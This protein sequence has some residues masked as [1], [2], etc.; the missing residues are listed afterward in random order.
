MES[1]GGGGHFS[2]AAAQLTNYTLEEAV[3]SLKDRVKV[4]LR[5]NGRL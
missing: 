5:D 1:Y 4:F 2:K 3:A